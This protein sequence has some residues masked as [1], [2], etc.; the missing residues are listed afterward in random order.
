MR[1]SALRPKDLVVELE[2]PVP[3]QRNLEAHVTASRALQPK[4]L[5]KVNRGVT[6]K[7]AVD[8]VVCAPLPETNIQF[9]VTRKLYIL[10]K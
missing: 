3:I 9:L 6:K 7:H 8:P 2:F 10:I 4:D 5:K 1:C